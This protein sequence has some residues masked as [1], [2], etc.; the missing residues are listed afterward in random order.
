[1]IRRSDKCRSILPSFDRIVFARE[2]E[3]STTDAVHSVIML[4]AKLIVY[5][6]YVTNDVL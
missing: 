2:K 3:R 5:V 1:M 4:Y 6:S